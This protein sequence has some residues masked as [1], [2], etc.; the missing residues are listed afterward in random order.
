V[1][2]V[3][4][5]A[6]L[7]RLASQGLVRQPGKGC[8]WRAGVREGAPN[9]ADPIAGQTVAVIG[10]RRVQTPLPEGYE[11]SIH[12]QAVRTL[13]ESDLHV[14]A[15]NLR[16]LDRGYEDA[17][18]RWRPAGL[19]LTYDAG[20]SPQALALAE[21]C[22]IQA[23]PVVV[24]GG[25]DR[26]SLFDRVDSDHEAGG[27]AVARHLIGRGCRRLLSFWRFPA[28]HEW[29]RQ[30]EAGVARA[31]REAGL[32]PSVIVRTPEL[33]EGHDRTED[34]FHHLARTLAGYLCDRLATPEGAIDGIVTAT[35]RHAI[36]T[37]AA[38]RFLGRAPGRAV[39]VAG[40]DNYWQGCVERAWEPE[41]PAITVDKDNARIGTELARLLLERLGERAHADTAPTV[42]IV[43]PRVVHPNNP[44]CA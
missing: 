16:A 39:H 9:G 10:A 19:L 24:Y 26:L 6:T 44:T 43:E 32:P 5:R 33:G 20:E 4:V 40:Y 30:R 25:G 23:V 1:S 31:L 28:Q 8:A 21:A 14:L 13:E 18:A 37:T 2:R 36:Q 12:A 35:D 27:Y 22:R 41:P 42:R 11:S 3:T 34:A 7:Q 17:V 38:L 29:V 15:V